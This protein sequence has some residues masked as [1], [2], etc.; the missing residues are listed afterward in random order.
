MLSSHRQ[1]NTIRLQAG[2]LTS[3]LWL[4]LRFFMRLSMLNFVSLRYKR[5]HAQLFFWVSGMLTNS[6][7]LYLAW[8]KSRK[9]LS[10]YK[11]LLIIFLFS[12]MIFSTVQQLLKPVI[13]FEKK[14][15]F[16][17]IC[18][19]A[20]ING[21]LFLVYMEG[22][23]QSKLSVSLYCGMVSIS[24]LIFAFHFIYRSYSISS[25]V[26]IKLTNRS[27]F[28]FRKSKVMIKL[29][30][31]KLTFIVVSLIVECIIWAYICHAY[32]SYEPR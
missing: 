22:D 1:Y 25:Y 20:T 8:T 4:F 18:K 26:P 19:V 3:T 23:E 21:N 28:N 30:F 7:A 31:Y 2:H 12:D 9:Q 13:S 10:E 32:L 27:H 15:N 17:I 24:F 11:K 6:I 14:H 16:L 5:F 29:D